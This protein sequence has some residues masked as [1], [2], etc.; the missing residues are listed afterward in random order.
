M[1]SISTIEKISNNMKN[2]TITRDDYE[3]MS[4]HNMSI[5]LSDQV[6]LYNTGNQW[7]IIPLIIALSYPIIYD[8]HEDENDSYDITIAVCPITLRTALFKG[9]FVFETYNDVT[10]I[11]K[12]KKSNNLIQIDM[13]YKI[14]KEYV[15]EQNKRSEIKIMTLRNSLVFAPDVKYMIVEKNIKIKPV[16]DISYYS[17]TEDIEGKKIDLLIH[18]KTLC[19]V[20]QYKKLEGDEKI[21]IVLGKDAHQ[22]LVTGYDLK[23]QVCLIILQKK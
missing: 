17:N 19:Y 15:I 22:S 20:I 16:L 4:D 11:L 12:E 13:A 9:T 10:M 6:I 18:P 1:S 21:K 5:K 8:K 7:K 23:N 2:L 14:D 3:F